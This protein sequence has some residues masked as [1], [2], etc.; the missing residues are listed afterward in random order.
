MAS[1]DLGNGHQ[2]PAS[3]LVVHYVRAS[4]PG[5]QNVNKV[6]TKVELRFQLQRSEA[7]SEARK[8][9]LARA[10]PGHVTSSGEFLITCDTH[11]SQQMN[12]EEALQ[13]LRQMILRVWTPP[14]P[15]KKTKPSAG[16]KARRL[17]DKRARSERKRQ[18]AHREH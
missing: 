2:L 15:R 18:R 4:G 13:R 1:L 3:D 7:L 16:A 17:A 14:R 10:Y 11:R 5:G 9:R 8:A 12:Y 6:A